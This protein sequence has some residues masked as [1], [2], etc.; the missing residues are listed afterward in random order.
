MIAGKGASSPFVERFAEDAGFAPKS[1]IQS[2]AFYARF[3][4][5]AGLKEIQCYQGRQ[6]TR[7]DSTLGACGERRI[8][9]KRLGSGIQL[10][11][12]SN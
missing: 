12:T 5:P 11:R 2:R 3:S 4:S 10:V 8:L 7:G 1:A 9:I 6:V